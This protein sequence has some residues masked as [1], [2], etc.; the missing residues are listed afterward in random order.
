ML[1]KLKKHLFQRRTQ[2]TTVQLSFE[3]LDGEMTTYSVVT[4]QTLLQAIRSQGKMVSSYCG[5]MCSCG[6]CVVF[7]SKGSVSEPTSREIA[8][9]GYSNYNSGERLACQARIVEDVHVKRIDR[10]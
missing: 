7:I 2:Q 6:T 1:R 10:Y 4:G 3:E 5:G 8:T 9:L